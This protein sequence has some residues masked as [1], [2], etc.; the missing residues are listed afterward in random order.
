MGLDAVTLV[1]DVETKFEIEI[2]DRDASKIVTVGDLLD[3]VWKVVQKSD[4][5]ISRKNM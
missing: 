2:D 1:H 5:S 4:N 3:L